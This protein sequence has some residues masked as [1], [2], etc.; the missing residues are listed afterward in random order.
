M[1]PTITVDTVGVMGFLLSL[2]H[3]CDRVPVLTLG[4]FFYPLN[5]T[6][7]LCRGGRD[8]ACFL[9]D[10]SNGRQRGARWGQE[11]VGGEGGGGGGDRTMRRPFSGWMFISMEHGPFPLLGEWAVLSD[12]PDTV[13]KLRLAHPCFTH[14]DAQQ[15][16]APWRRVHFKRALNWNKTFLIN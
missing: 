16:L 6:P 1:Q 13:N 12:I 7:S 5:K 4:E 11:G 2:W 14:T 10:V 8:P 9:V 15:R 3:F